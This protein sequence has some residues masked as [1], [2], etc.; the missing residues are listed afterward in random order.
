M[1]E[2][3]TPK[4]WRSLFSCPSIVIDDNGYIYS[5]AEYKKLLKT[6]IGRIDYE[7]DNIYGSDYAS[8]NATPIA[9]MIHSG[10]TTKVY[11]YGKT[12]FSAPM[13][14]IKNDRIYTPEEYTRFLGGQ[15]SGYVKTD[16]K[17]SFD[18]ILNHSG[19]GNS[20]IPNPS[21]SGSFANTSSQNNASSNTSSGSS[22]PLPGF[23][24]VLGVA[25]LAGLIYL[26]S[27]E[28]RIADAS[29]VLAIAAN[30]GAAVYFLWK[31]LKGELHFMW[32]SKRFA[33]GLATGIGIY[34]AATAILVLLGLGSNI[35]SGHAISDDAGNQ[36][37]LSAMLIGLPFVISGLFHEGA[38]P[39]AK[40]P[41]RS[42]VRSKSR[43]FTPS[44]KASHSS[45]P[46]NQRGAS[47]QSAGKIFGSNKR[48]AKC[49]YCRKNFWVSVPA[50]EKKLAITCPNKLCRKQL[51]V[52]I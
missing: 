32:N 12:Q 27:S 36:M 41:V 25:I 8:W 46:Q 37:E 5:A 3:Y 10:E 11:E 28:S 26:L 17:S 35:G 4:E 15:P 50:G 20:N 48:L 24:S 9:Y 38:V 40:Q 52:T 23:I 22:V 39:N 16:K 6:P 45:A 29:T 33:K 19:K 14:Y 13:L 30:I 43:S 18:D 21:G 31:K 7:K 2:I 42:N 47:S 1:T 44:S 51:I 49:P 34:V